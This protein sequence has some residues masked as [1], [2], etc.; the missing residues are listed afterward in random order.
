MTVSNEVKR[1]DIMKVV[2]INGSPRKGNTYT[3][4]EIFKD[5]MNKCGK[6]LITEF[7]MPDDMPKFCMGCQ[8]CLGNSYDKCPHHKFTEPIYKAIMDADAIVLTSPHFGASSVPGSM[9]NLLDHLDFLTMTVAPRKEIFEKKAFVLTTGTGSAASIKMLSTYLKHWGI[10]RV[11][12]LGIKL[13]TDKWSSMPK[14][15]QEYQEARIRKAARRFYILKKKPAYFST[16]FMY[17]INRIILKKYV[18]EGNYPYEYWKENG[19]FDKC[20]F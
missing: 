3:A 5:E 7:F 12:S 16:V 11:Y 1:R 13:F 4:T 14:E 20:P 9:Q 10:N 17:Y 6:T 8:V 2:I 19:Y 15:K 18:G